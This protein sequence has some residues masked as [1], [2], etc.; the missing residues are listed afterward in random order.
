M[1]EKREGGAVKRRVRGWWF[2]MS[3]VVRH[4]NFISPLENILFGKD[5]VSAWW[6]RT[7]VIPV[8]LLLVVLRFSFSNAEFSYGKIQTGFS[9]AVF[10]KTEKY[11][12]SDFI[13]SNIEYYGIP[14]ITSRSRCTLINHHPSN[15]FPAAHAP[16]YPQPARCLSWS[17]CWSCGYP[18]LVLNPE[19]QLKL[20]ISLHF[21]ILSDCLI[22]RHLRSPTWSELGTHDHPSSAWLIFYPEG[23]TYGCRTLDFLNSNRRKSGTGRKGSS[24]CPNTCFLF[25]GRLKKARMCCPSDVLFTKTEKYRYCRFALQG[26]ICA[27]QLGRSW[28]HT[29]TLAPPGWSSTP[30][31]INT[32]AAR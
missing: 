10:T 27:V 17:V 31:G 32:D 25:L 24:C 7:T 19:L 9:D 28:V 16:G 26:G 23:H 30:K 20:P 12:Y 21:Q 1:I 5:R 11:R 13:H 3:N 14:T 4:G 29:I 18:G 8:S 22:R 2:Q 6:N 15:S